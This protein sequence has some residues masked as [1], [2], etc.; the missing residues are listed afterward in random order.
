MT[1]TVALR[2]SALFALLSIMFGAVSTGS[3]APAAQAL[4]LTSL[5]LGALTT[6]FA[7]ATPSP[8]PVPVRIRR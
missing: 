1:R 3:Q 2:A 5:A 6:L 7:L 8:A 4:F